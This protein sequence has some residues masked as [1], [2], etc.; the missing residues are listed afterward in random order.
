M[1]LIFVSCSVGTSSCQ[2]RVSSSLP[3]E[4]KVPYQMI[5]VFSLPKYYEA[6]LLFIAFY[7]SWYSKE[8]EYIKINIHIHH[9]LT[10]FSTVSKSIHIHCDTNIRRLCSLALFCQSSGFPKTLSCMH[11]KCTKCLCVFHALF[12][13]FIH[14][15]T[16]YVLFMNFILEFY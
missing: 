3:C 4:S 10:S 1:L 6:Q 8:Q 2:P 16:N 9:L 5:L 11:C 13:I 15:Y 14:F 7:I 12:F